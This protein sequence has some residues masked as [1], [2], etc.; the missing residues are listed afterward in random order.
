M[1]P[2]ALDAMGGELMPETAVIGAGIAAA[3]GIPIVLVGNQEIIQKELGRKGLS[4][5]IVHASDVINMD[6]HA[7]DVRK[8]RDSSVS[9]AMQ[10]V[11]NG[12]A[13]GCISMG[14]SGAT[15]TAALLSLGRITGVARPAI[16]T[17]I[18]LDKRTVGLLDIGANADCRPQYLQQFGIMG[19]I[20]V[21]EVLDVRSP[22]VGLLSIG[23]E[24]HKGNELTRSA[25]EI[26][27]KTTGLRF[28]GN[29][30]GRDLF[31]DAADV[32]VTDGFT[33][34]IVLKLAEGEARAI[35]G[36]LRQAVRSTVWAR[37]GGLFVRPALRKVA[38]RLDPS[39]YGAQP[40]LGVKGYAFIGHGRSNS[41]AVY[42]ALK[43]A[44]DS[45]ERRVVEKIV[46]G[47]KTFEIA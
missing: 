35:F 13:S 26:L 34:N 28:V 20:Y 19:A 22:R 33:G 44:Q 11:A 1:K 10:L 4:L 21:R 40:L 16:F 7:V 3:E 36:C 39:E 12:D 24:P 43:N 27:S 6:D 9:V 14:H 45:I 42:N 30:E 23:E 37:I 5:P 25:H 2:I 31:S 17:T 38:Q 15:M 18:R 32:I 47:I 41:R 29:V 8:R 46:E